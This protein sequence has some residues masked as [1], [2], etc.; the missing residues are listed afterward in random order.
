MTLQRQK[1]ILIAVFVALYSVLF[2]LGFQL[3]ITRATIW[4]LWAAVTLIIGSLIWCA[5]ITCATAF[6]VNR[7]GSNIFTCAIPSILLLGLGFFRLDVAVGAI[8]V[9]LMLLMVQRR[10]S[11]ELSSRVNVHVIPVFSAATRQVI[12][13]LLI[14]LIT[15]SLP[16]LAKSFDNNQIAVPPSLIA[17]LT[18]P[19]ESLIQG[20]LPGYTNGSTIDQIIDRQLQ[21][22][23]SSLPG[24][25]L[26]PAQ[27]IASQRTAIRQEF[28][29][30]FSM[31]LTGR[32]T[33]PDILA[34]TMNKYLRQMAQENRLIAIIFVIALTFV[35]VRVIV[36]VVVWPTLFLIRIFLRLSE[37]IGLITILRTQVTVERISL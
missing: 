37:Q 2:F 11:W 6:V 21:N 25:A 18:A 27:V 35:T 29:R 24:E 12:F 17:S 7:S 1:E 10:L 22:Q 32:E 30:Q 8:V 13:A 23:L 36:P 3:I 9:F 19:F 20:L 5:L 28:S 34:G 15:L 4:S 33:L 14:S 26:I 16:T 31:T